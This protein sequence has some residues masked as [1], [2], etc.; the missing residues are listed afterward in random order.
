MIKMPYD[1]LIALGSIE[2]GN[3]YI[4]PLDPLGKLFSTH[5]EDIHTIT[6]NGKNIKKQI[7]KIA[8]VCAEILEDHYGELQT[9]PNDVKAL[10]IDIATS[11]NPKNH[12]RFLTQRAEQYLRKMGLVPKTL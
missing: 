2:K 7:G 12:G 3:A 8:P 6:N 1:S 5:L 11:A 9:L 4:N 10:I